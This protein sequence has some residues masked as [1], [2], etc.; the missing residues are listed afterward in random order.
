MAN[1]DKTAQAHAQVPAADKERHA[2][3][4]AQVPAA[5]KDRHKAATANDDIQHFD[6]TIA[7]LVERD[8]PDDG[9]DGEEGKT[10][11]EWVEVMSDNLY[12]GEK[13][14]READKEE[15]DRKAEVA[16]KERAKDRDADKR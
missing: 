9:T 15:T 3:G 13:L 2:Q 4:S 11:K 6:T 10:H 8:V 14:K 7:K 5:D 16:R 12:P 1:D